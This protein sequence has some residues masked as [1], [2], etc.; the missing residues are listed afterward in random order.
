MLSRI[1][2]V[3]DTYDAMTTER[4]YRARLGHR[5][6][7][8]EL[9]R[10]AGRQLDPETVRAFLRLYEATAPTYPAFPSGLRELA[11]VALPALDP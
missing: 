7:V 8:E 1:L 10:C 2:A 4:P 6:A 3:C 11:E 5:A 9:V